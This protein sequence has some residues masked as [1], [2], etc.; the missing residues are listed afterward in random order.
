M[1]RRRIE[2]RKVVLKDLIRTER[3]K[4]SGRGRKGNKE[5]EKERRKKEGRDC[6]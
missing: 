1:R 2:V 4:E 6:I 3:R 5:E